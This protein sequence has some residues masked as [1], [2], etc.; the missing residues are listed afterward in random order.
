MSS[1]GFLKNKYD[2]ILVIKSSISLLVD[3]FILSV[4]IVFI[5]FVEYCIELFFDI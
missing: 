4:K 3:K 5:T 2:D 1:N